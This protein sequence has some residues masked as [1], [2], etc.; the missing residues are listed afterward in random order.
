MPSPRN[1]TLAELVGFAEAVGFQGD[2]AKTMAAISMAESSGNPNAVNYADPGGSYGLTQVNA[3]AHGPSAMQ[4]LGNPQ[5]AFKQAF[6]ISGGG[7]NFTPWSV[8]NNGMY[9]PH[10]AALGLSSGSTAGSL[11]GGAIQTVSNALGLGGGS[12]GQQGSLTGQSATGSPI[13]SQSPLSAIFAA[14]GNFFQTAGVLI[15]GVVLVAIGAW[16]IAKPRN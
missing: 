16:Y 1:Y 13:I 12:G 3:A 11:G 8:Y 9:L 10:A 6:R 14:L 2:Q 15:L 5:E 7:S 4:T